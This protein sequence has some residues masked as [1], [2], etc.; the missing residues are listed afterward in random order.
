MLKKFLHHPLCHL[1][2]ILLVGA[3][4]YANS[5]QV[6]FVLDDL[7]LIANNDIIRNLGNFLPGGSGYDFTPRR[8]FGYFTF[9]LNYHFGG[10]DVTGYHLFNLAVHLCTALLVYALVRLTFRTPKLSA[11]GLV[12]QAGTVALLA[13]LFFV[14]HPVQTQAVTYI[15]Q[16]LASLCTLFYLLALVLYVAARLGFDNQAAQGGGWRSLAAGG[17]HGPLLLTGSFVAALLAMC[18][19]E[20]AFTLPLVIVLYE[21][22]FFRGQWQRRA[23]ILLPLLLTLP[24]IPYSIL[25]SGSGVP[26][27]DG[28]A[29]LELQLRAHTDLPR[30]HYLFTQFRVI[31]TYLRLLILPVGQNLDYD[32]PVF[33]TL[34]TP[35][36]LLSCL[37]LAALLVLAIY[38]Y[39]LSSEAVDPARVALHE[40]RLVAFGIVWFFLT[41]A[42]ESGLV[43]LADV[44]FEHRLYL[45]S[46]G[47][48]IALAVLIVL[49]AQRVSLR[50]VARLVLPVAM[51][52]IAL[53]VVATW[54]RN[55][56][57]Q[58]EISLW[59]DA[60]RKSPAKARP[61]YNLGTHLIKAGDANQ[62]IQALSQAVKLDPE[63]AKAWHNLGRALLMAG[64]Y[65][66]ALQPLRKSVK[67]DAQHDNAV[68]NLSVAL[69]YTNQPREAVFRLEHMRQKFP[70]RPDVRYNL[71]LAYLGTGKLDDARGELAVLS[72]I[73]PAVA[74]DLAAQISQA[75]PSPASK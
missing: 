43:P 56:V 31:V 19:K 12:S 65:R 25:T 60:A 7:E 18:T 20:I 46:I 50:L 55:Q 69:I 28:A 61:W 59:T 39:R 13:A 70:E 21:A 37:L 64:R 41:L 14:A 47:L 48:A 33:T 35:P 8:W 72:R 51:L 15:V 68:I 44:I 57:W 24:L 53:L 9:A 54:Q 66:E 2:L 74:T 3:V 45:P 49:A 4:A 40:L 32:Y 75:A 63:H 23:L 36:V 30:L 38:L 52:T 62:A 73:A 71:G 1:L 34:F 11:S 26:L 27:E 67:L 22:S 5:F 16:R 29:D 42:V 58:S 10:L 6:P 17:W